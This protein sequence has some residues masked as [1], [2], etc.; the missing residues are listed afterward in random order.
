MGEF[1]Q[2]DGRSLGKY[3][4]LERRLL[5]GDPDALRRVSR[6]IAG[7]LA[8]TRFWRLRAQWID[9]HQETMMRVVE[10]LRRGRFD[11]SRDF[12]VYVQAVAR[13]TAMET[14]KL[15]DRV[16]EIEYREASG[17]GQDA[18]VEAR[19]IRRQLVRLVLQAATQECRE[20][21]L[22]YYLEQRDYDEIASSTKAPVGT[23]KS[24]LFRCL[25]GANRAIRRSDA[26]RARAT[27]R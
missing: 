22:A 18:G 24:K 16:P 1:S 9:I 7:V 8:S 15:Q 3:S 26:T 25:E 14:L 27:S 2:T 17:R 23:V 5:A 4:G 10:S 11:A 19:I 21:I 12:L 20:L 6:L 13:Y